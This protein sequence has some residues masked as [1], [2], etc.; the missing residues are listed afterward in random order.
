MERGNRRHR[1]MQ[2]SIYRVRTQRSMEHRMA[3][4][5]L[6]EMQAGGRRHASNTLHRARTPSRFTVEPGAVKSVTVL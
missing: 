4:D 6:R 2:K 3:M 1:K 5:L